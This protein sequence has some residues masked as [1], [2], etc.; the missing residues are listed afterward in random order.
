DLDAHLAVDEGL[1]DEEG[2][3]GE[4]LGRAALAPA[5]EPTARGR[6]RKPEHARLP[7]YASCGIRIGRAPCESAHDLG[8]L[9]ARLGGRLEVDGRATEG[10]DPEVLLAPLLDRHA[11]LLGPSPHVTHGG[12]SLG[13]GVGPRV[14]QL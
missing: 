4:E 6:A 5:A 3:D 8:R 9:P 11:R 13:L 12:T 10:V 7:A 14:R 2:I 1:V